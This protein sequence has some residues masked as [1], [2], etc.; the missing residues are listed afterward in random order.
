MLFVKYGFLLRVDELDDCKEER[1][2]DE[3]LGKDAEFFKAR[4]DALAA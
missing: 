2:D 1:R 3:G 4:R